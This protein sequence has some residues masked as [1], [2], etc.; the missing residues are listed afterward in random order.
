MIIKLNPTKNGKVSPVPVEGL[1]IWWAIR[2]R[3]I[4]FGQTSLSGVRR[5]FMPPQLKTKQSWKPHKLIR[6]LGSTRLPERAWIIILQ[7]FG[8]R[9]S[10]AA[11]LHCAQCAVLCCAIL[12]RFVS[13]AVNKNTSGWKMFTWSFK[14]SAFF[15][16]NFISYLLSFFSRYA[17]YPLR[18]EAAMW[19]KYWIIYYDIRK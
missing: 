6:I 15:Y 4:G 13:L 17:T 14:L 10:T 8:S 9:T 12:F 2:N 18:L 3:K 5:G 7:K 16:F 11:P 1:Q 19:K